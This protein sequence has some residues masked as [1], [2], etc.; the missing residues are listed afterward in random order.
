ME[1]ERALDLV[2]NMRFDKGSLG[3]EAVATI[4]IGYLDLRNEKDKIIADLESYAE[5]VHHEEL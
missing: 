4:A 2:R 5:Q 3:E 1:I